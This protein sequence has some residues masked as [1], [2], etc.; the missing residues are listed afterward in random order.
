[1][2]DI[3]EAMQAVF[4]TDKITMWPDG[5][6]WVND[7][8]HGCYV[9]RIVEF[10]ELE[11]N[12]EFH[13]VQWDQTNHEMIDMNIDKT[14]NTHEALKQVKESLQR[15]INEPKETLSDVK[16]LREMLRHAKHG[17]AVIN[18]AIIAASFEVTKTPECGAISANGEIYDNMAEMNYKAKQADCLRMWLDDRRVPQADEFGTVFSLVDRVIRYAE[19]SKAITSTLDEPR[20]KNDAS[21]DEDE[22]KSM[23]ERGTLAWADVQ[24]PPRWVDALRGNESDK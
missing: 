19:K 12:G 21:I 16:A 22:F 3:N 6:V 10:L 11:A 8:K 17:M 15:I 4:D 13:A 1:M 14:Y 24:D 18:S 20:A 9:K 23:V 5:F 2:S 7:G